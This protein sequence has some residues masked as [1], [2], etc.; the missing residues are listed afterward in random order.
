MS[1]SKTRCCEERLL[2]KEGRKGPLGSAVHE[3]VQKGAPRSKN[4]LLLGVG[5][6]PIKASAS[7]CG[8]HAEERVRKTHKKM[9]PC[10]INWHGWRNDPRASLHYDPSGVHQLKDFGH[11]RKS[12][13]G[14]GLK[15]PV[16]TATSDKRNTW[17]SSIWGQANIW[18]VLASGVHQCQ[19]VPPPVAGDT[20]TAACH[21][22]LGLWPGLEEQRWPSG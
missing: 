19:L 6:L 21:H 18:L 20:L 10:T 2:K 7:H 14:W 22:G 11:G 15:A 8:G 4:P 3:W 5:A 13:L 17:Q 12:V 16:N 1:M 9:P